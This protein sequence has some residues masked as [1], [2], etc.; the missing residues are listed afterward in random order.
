MTENASESTTSPL[1]AAFATWPRLNASLRETVLRLTPAQLALQPSPSQWPLW[2]TVGH[3]ACQ[4]VFWLCDF[5]GE[6]GADTTPFTN[7]A[8]DCPGDDDLENVLGPEEL[9]AAL[10]S[11]F[12][13]VERCLDTWEVGSLPESIRWPEF[14]PDWVMGRGEVLGRTFAHDVWHAGQLSL[15]LSAHGL[16]R[17]DVW[18]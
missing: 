10:D 15:T 13:I 17:V 1:R 8:F 12:A 11:T 2:A 9:A 4:R 16:G 3:L 6:P 5:A 7:A 14:G 18:S